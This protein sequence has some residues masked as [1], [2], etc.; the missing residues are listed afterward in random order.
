MDQRNHI[1]CANSTLNQNPGTSKGPS[2]KD[3]SAIRIQ[4]YDTVWAEAGVVGPD[5]C[6]CGSITDDRIDHC[7][8]NELKI[9]PG[10][11]GTQVAGNRSST[12]SALELRK[13][14]S[15]VV[16]ADQREMNSLR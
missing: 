6:D 15:I 8:S 16:K 10:L 3:D 9:A 14:R 4:G 1:C 5:A 13:F 2:G 7:V 11:C 12:L